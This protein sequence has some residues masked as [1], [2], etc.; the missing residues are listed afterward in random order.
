MNS[1]MKLKMRKALEQCKSNIK[2]I[3]EA[4][5]DSP[6]SKNAKHYLSQ[7]EFNILHSMHEISWIGL[8]KEDNIKENDVLIVEDDNPSS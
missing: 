2:A 5:A 8:R 7:A 1:D 6:D 3:R 4:M